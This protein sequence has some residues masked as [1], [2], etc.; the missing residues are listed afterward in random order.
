MNP[1]TMLAYEVLR[2]RERG[3]S[4]R[5]ISRS[6]GIARKTIRRMLRDLERRREG[7]PNLKTLESLRKKS[8]FSGY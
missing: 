1:R 4:L 5:A 2:R 3:Q 6:L 7:G 8:R